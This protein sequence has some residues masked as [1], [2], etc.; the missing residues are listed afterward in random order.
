MEYSLFLVA[1][2]GAG[3]VAGQ[4]VG[5]P[6]YTEYICNTSTQTF[7]KCVNG[8]YQADHTCPSGR[9]CFTTGLA[10]GGV[11][12]IERN[13]YL[14]LKI[15]HL[16]AKGL[17]LCYRD[18]DCYKGLTCVAGVC[19]FMND[20]K[21][22]NAPCADGYKYICDNQAQVLYECVN[23]VYKLHNACPSGRYCFTTGLLV[24]GIDIIE[25]NCYLD[26]LIPF[27][28]VKGVGLCYQN[29]DCASPLACIANVCT[30]DT[31]RYK[32]PGFWNPVQG[33]YLSMC[34]DKLKLNEREV[35]N[36]VNDY[37]IFHFYINC[38]NHL[39]KPCYDI[40]CLL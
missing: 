32:L 26:G 23:G 10:I 6:C 2:L 30:W 36:D 40:H 24:G 28:G 8:A 35:Q 27:A 31:N 13:C 5:D 29:Q 17:D 14:D 18:S 20:L 39:N 33:W 12:I 21:S 9:F 37:H 38:A 7:F 1:L 3:L 4:Q 34:P 25:K 15:P 16:V 11:D 22:L 19:S